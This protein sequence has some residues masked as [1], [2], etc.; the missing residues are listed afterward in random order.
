VVLGNTGR[1]EV[2]CDAVFSAIA[3]NPDLPLTDVYMYETAMHPPYPV[4]PNE[5]Q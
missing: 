1:D 4:A 2:T 5:H 3:L